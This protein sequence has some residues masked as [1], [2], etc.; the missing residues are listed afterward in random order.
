MKRAK[1][2]LALVLMLALMATMGVCAF[3]EEDETAIVVMAEAEGRLLVLCSVS[4]DTVEDSVELAQRAADTQREH[5]LRLGAAAAMIAA[6]VPGI[7]ALFA[8]FR[9]RRGWLLLF[10]SLSFLFGAAAEALSF[11]AA[12]GL[13]YTVLFVGVF[14]AA[15]LA[16]NLKKA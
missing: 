3:A 15:V 5:M 11:Y 1:R 4:A 9:D 2:I 6:S 8:A 14:A 16:L 13:I 7:L 12:R 10:T